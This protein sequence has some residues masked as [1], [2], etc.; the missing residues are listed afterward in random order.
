MGAGQSPTSLTGLKGAS[1]GW[2]TRGDTCRKRVNPIDPLPLTNGWAAQPSSVAHLAHRHKNF[3]HRMVSRDNVH[4][5]SRLLLCNTGRKKLRWCEACARSEPF[6]PQILFGREE[7][8]AHGPFLWSAG[9]KIL[10]KAANIHVI[11]AT[12]ADEGPEIVCFRRAKS[13]RKRIR[14]KNF[15]H[16]GQGILL[17]SSVDAQLFIYD[18]ITDD[19]ICKKLGLLRNCVEIPTFNPR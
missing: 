12:Q 3:T 16:G 9:K 6:C 5:V 2:I 10:E 13:L 7:P 17:L 11:T 18:A 1:P 15:L 19:Y 14:Q 4:R 8:N